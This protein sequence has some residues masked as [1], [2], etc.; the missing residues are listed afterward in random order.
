MTN[1]EVIKLCESTKFHLVC[2]SKE[3]D[4]FIKKNYTDGND[5][6]KFYKVYREGNDAK[7]GHYMINPHTM[8]KRNSTFDEFYGGGIVD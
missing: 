6:G 5:D 8:H 4:E 2:I 1:E 3:M 7:Y